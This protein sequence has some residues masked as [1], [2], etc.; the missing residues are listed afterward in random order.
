MRRWLPTLA[1]YCWPASALMAPD[2]PPF[3]APHRVQTVE[4]RIIRA[5][6]DAGIPPHVALSVAWR[7]SRLRPDAEHRNR[8][9]SVDRGVMQLNS[10]WHPPMAWQENIDTGIAI[11]A[12]KTRKCG[13]AGMY[14]AYNRGHCPKERGK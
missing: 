5:A 9:G 7:E 11:I 8:D 6:L 12:E 13:A 3:P 14:F 2:S 4:S 1:A 10:R